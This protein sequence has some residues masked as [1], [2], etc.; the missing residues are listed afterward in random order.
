MIVRR[1]CKMISTGKISNSHVEI[2]S[3]YSK[4]FSSHTRKLFIAHPL[5]PHYLQISLEKSMCQPVEKLRLGLYLV[6]LR[7]TLNHNR[8]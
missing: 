3:S 5:C 7:Y 1:L 8:R 4:S 2:V 6:T